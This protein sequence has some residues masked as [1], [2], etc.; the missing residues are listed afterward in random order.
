MFI[1]KVIIGS[2]EDNNKEIAIVA[3][4]SN[5]QNGAMRYLITNLPE[6]FQKV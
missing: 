1:M 5:E 2:I 6:V 3:S 4:V